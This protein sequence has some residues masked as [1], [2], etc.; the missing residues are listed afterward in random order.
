MALIKRILKNVSQLWSEGK[1][2]NRVLSFLIL[3]RMLREQKSEL[4][5]YIMKKL[6]ISYIKNCKYTNEDNFAMINFMKQ[7]L[8]EL[9]SLDQGVAYQ[10]AFIYI[11][12][13]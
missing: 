7:S 6:Y 11:R 1:E 10:H 5:N 12:Y 9:Y 8:V 2:E 13:L 4:I 3:I